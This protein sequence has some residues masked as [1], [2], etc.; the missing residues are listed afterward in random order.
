MRP[1][2]ADNQNLLFGARLEQ[3]L[4]H[5]H[6]LF[7]FADAID[8]SEFEEAFGKLYDPGQGRHE[9]TGRLITPL[10]FSTDCHRMRLV[11]LETDFGLCVKD[12]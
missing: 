5:N 3:I 12:S 11:A 6:S 4:D 10:S 1:K 7:K 8:R 9:E 2:P